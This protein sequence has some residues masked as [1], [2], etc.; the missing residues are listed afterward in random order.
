ML[1]HLDLPIAI[2][3]FGIASLIIVACLPLLSLL[4]PLVQN[5]S[6]VL[7]VHDKNTTEESTL[8][9]S[10]SPNVVTAG[11]TNG[12]SQASQTID[13]V[14]DST[15]NGI[16][17][18]SVGLYNGLRQIGSFSATTIKTCAVSTWKGALIV[19]DFVESGAYYLFNNLKNSAIF[20]TR[21]P[22]YAS[23]QIARIPSLY[24]Y[25]RP[26]V[27]A[28][29]A[30]IEPLRSDTVQK[31]NLSPNM[32]P[33]N[34]SGNPSA[35]SSLWPINGRI[36]AGFGVPHRP[37]QLYHTG[38]DISSGHQSGAT[39]VKPFRSGIV[40]EVV[41]S[42]YGL[43]NHVVVSHGNG[44]TSVYA[45]LSSVAVSKKQPVNTSTILGQEGTTGLSTGTHLHFEIRENGKAVNPKD[46]IQENP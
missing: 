8:V 25:L 16:H 27:Y 23:K 12:T 37:F 3:R 40:E 9:F 24:T 10:D 42:R 45:H 29:T 31:Y 6:R 38:I 20:I 41:W 13:S 32:Q 14:M 21:I 18:G 46:Y 7:S 34:E 30:T 33:N 43:G 28:Q 17:K 5:D 22:G 39:A 26:S 36:T 44:L 4:P 2:L 15:W 1:R 35:S 11:L 19:S